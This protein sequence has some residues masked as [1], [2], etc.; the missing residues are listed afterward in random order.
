[1]AIHLMRP[2]LAEHLMRPRLAEQ[3]GPEEA[4]LLKV[5]QEFTKNVSL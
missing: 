1:M 5:Q 3:L 2:W 4:K